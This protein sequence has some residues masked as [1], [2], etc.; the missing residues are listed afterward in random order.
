MKKQSI[1]DFIDRLTQHIPDKFFKMIRYYGFLS[2]RTR[3][4]ILPKFMIWSD[5]LLRHISR[6]PLLH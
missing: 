3:T 2:Y 4:I 6:S 1:D 5:K